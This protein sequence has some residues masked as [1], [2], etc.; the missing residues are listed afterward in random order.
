MKGDAV[1]VTTAAGEVMQVTIPDTVDEAW[2]LF[3][4]AK[5]RAA[6]ATVKTI[7]REFMAKWHPDRHASD[8]AK[9][10]L[11][12]FQSLRANAAWTILEKHCRW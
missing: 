5:K 10:L 11:A 6:K 9:L 3:G 2:A 8:P 7:Y 12:N 4:I 1:E